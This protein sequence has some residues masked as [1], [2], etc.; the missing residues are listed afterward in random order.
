MPGGPDSGAK[1]FLLSKQ[2]LNKNV[3][4]LTP[5]KPR[6]KKQ[7]ESSGGPLASFGNFGV[8]NDF[9]NSNFVSY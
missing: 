4:N 3:T 6:L 9:I 5:L 1:R 2:F 8:N 7:L